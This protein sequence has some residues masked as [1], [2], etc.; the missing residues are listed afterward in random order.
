MIP[1][2]ASGKRFATRSPALSSVVSGFVVGFD[3]N[4]ISEAISHL[5]RSYRTERLPNV[6]TVIYSLVINHIT[7]LSSH[8]KCLRPSL[9]F[10]QKN[11]KNPFVRF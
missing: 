4:K 1:L 6:M 5:I 10:F 2:I 3:F 8:A 9:D 11:F 7:G